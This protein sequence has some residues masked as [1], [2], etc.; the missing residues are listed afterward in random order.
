MK[1]G[2]V[3][4]IPPRERGSAAPDGAPPRRISKEKT[5]LAPPC[6]VGALMRGGIASI[7]EKKVPKSLC[8][9]F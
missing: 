1:M 8:L 6:P 4:P 2:A 5:A 9:F 3:A 7:S